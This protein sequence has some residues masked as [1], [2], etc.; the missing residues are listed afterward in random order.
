MKRIPL[1]IPFSLALTATVCTS[2]FFPHFKLHTFAPFLALLYA[3]CSRMSS[4]W[5]S[6]LCGLIVDLLI[7][8]SRFGMYA[9]SFTSATLLLYGQKKHFSDKPLALSLFT[10]QISLVITS[11]LFLFSYSLFK[12]DLRW[13]FSDFILMSFFDSV[14]AALWFSAPLLAFESLRKMDLRKWIALLALKKKN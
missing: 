4:L 7:S 11:V 10:F 6:S 1:L 8:E 14:Y 3:R 13:I 9:C 12:L 2:V 5:I